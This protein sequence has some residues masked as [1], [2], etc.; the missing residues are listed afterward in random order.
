[1]VLSIDGSMNNST[2]TSNYKFISNSTDLKL[3][4]WDFKT[5]EALKVMEFATDIIT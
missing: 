1:M 4:L 5:G 3:I 2:E